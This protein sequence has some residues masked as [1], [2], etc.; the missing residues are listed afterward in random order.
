MPTPGRTV[1]SPRGYSYLLGEQI[2]TGAFGAVFNCVGPFD[3]SYAIKIFFPGDRLQGA[4]PTADGGD[5]P[6]QRGGI[7]LLMDQIMR[8]DRVSNQVVQ[9]GPRR[10]DVVETAGDRRP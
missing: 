10:L 8:L 2:G 4:G 3:Q 9:L 5:R 6:P 7:P 1:W